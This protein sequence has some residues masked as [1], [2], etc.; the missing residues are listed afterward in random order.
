MRITKN[1]LKQIIKEELAGVLGEDNDWSEIDDMFAQDAK[2]RETAKKKKGIPTSIKTSPSVAPE[3]PGAPKK[4]LGEKK[5]P[6]LTG[7]GKVT[8]AD[9]LKGRGVID[10]EEVKVFDDP[11]YKPEPEPK[12]GKKKKPKDVGNPRYNPPKKKPPMKPMK[13]KSK[14]KADK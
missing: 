11:T 10:E 8:Q 7:D 4:K 2:E 1:Q 9:I 6:D 12:P 13:N 14:S 3:I 5:F